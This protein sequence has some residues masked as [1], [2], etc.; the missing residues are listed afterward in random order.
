MNSTDRSKLQVAVEQVLMYMAQEH[1]QQLKVRHSDLHKL[2]NLGNTRFG[3]LKDAVDI[4]LGDPH[5]VTTFGN[6][7]VAD[8]G[9]VRG[10]YM[11]ILI[12]QQ[13]LVNTLTLDTV[14][15]K[16]GRA[17]AFAS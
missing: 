2:A 5:T 4:V 12:K 8:Y 16:L 15:G 13:K 6:W 3:S 1:I 10:D 9:I 7:L 14:S 17:R 11:M